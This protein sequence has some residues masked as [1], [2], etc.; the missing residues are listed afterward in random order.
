MEPAV[1]QKESSQ[2]TAHCPDQQTIGPVLL[3]K[4]DDGVHRSGNIAD[5]RAFVRR[6]CGCR[7]AISDTR[8]AEMRENCD[9][10]GLV[11]GR[12]PSAR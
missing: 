7:P 10:G 6:V 12:E 5:I 3:H 9:R 11:T 2:A 8:D 1:D 4:A